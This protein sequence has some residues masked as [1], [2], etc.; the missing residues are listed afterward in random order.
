[1]FK[2]TSRKIKIAKMEIKR[3]IRAEV[4]VSL[5]PWIALGSPLLMVIRIKP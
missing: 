4:M 5:A 2:A 3:P 1:M